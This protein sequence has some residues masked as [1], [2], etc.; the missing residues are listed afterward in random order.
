[1]KR[2]QHNR[3][4]VVLIAPIPPPNGG[5]ALQA[6]QLKRLLEDDGY[7]VHYTPTN[8]SIPHD[9]VSQTRYLRALYRLYFY[10]LALFKIPQEY[11]VWHIFSN[12]GISWFLFSFPAIFVGKIRKR[13]VIVNYRGGGADK[14][15][16][17]W[18]VAVK[19]MINWANDV[20]VP[21]HYLK[22]IFEKYR[23]TSSVIPNIVDETK[24]YPRAHERIEPLLTKSEVIISV[25]RN[26]EHIYGIDIAIE[27]F[28]IAKRKIPQL[29][30]KI[31]GE[32]V[33]EDRL[34]KLVRD[35]GLQNDVEFLGRLSPNE[36]LNLYQETDIL[37]NPSLVDNMP[38]ALL[39]AMAC[40]LPIISSN[41]GGIPYM[42]EHLQSAWIVPAGDVKRLSEAIISLVQDD[43]LRMSLAQT[44]FKRSTIYFW[45]QVKQTWEQIYEIGYQ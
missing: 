26:L 8:L 33:I 6:L 23:I 4:Q 45:P 27:A 28:G 19:Y 22:D 38:N 3:K 24:F 20:V 18:H 35:S 43:V 41:A 10:C 17:R 42:V 25:G 11:K 44:A 14:F 21:S 13:H 15:L 5:M 2:S 16:K 34:K 36:M 37:I 30:L 12:S 29:K 40:A 1:M 39:E 31:A 7:E 9:W 32:G